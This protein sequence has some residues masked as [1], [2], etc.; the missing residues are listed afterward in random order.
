LA[1]VAFDVTGMDM[2]GGRAGVPATADLAAGEPTAAKFADDGGAAGVRPAMA[3][4]CGVDC[5]DGNVGS[6]D[7]ATADESGA[8]SCFQNAQECGADWQPASEANVA[9]VIKF[10]MAFRF[11]GM[12]LGRFGPTSQWKRRLVACEIADETSLYESSA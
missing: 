6:A 11:M 10:W 2:L 3:T 12:E 9:N 8:A 5:V 4:G 7:R 1:N